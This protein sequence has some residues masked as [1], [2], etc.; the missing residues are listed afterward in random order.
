VKEYLLISEYLNDLTPP[1][2]LPYSYS[3]V[4]LSSILI[5][6]FLSRY[7]WVEFDFCRHLDVRDYID[8]FRGLCGQVTGRQVLSRGATP[9][10]G[11]CRTLCPTDI[12]PCRTATV[13]CLFI[14][15][16]EGRGVILGSNRLGA[17]PRLRPEACLHCQS[18][19]TDS[20]GCRSYH[21]EFERLRFVLVFHSS[22]YFLASW[23]LTTYSRWVNVD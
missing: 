17:S 23:D 6:W 16:F 13:W 21:F 22:L 8:D 3:D 1:R 18:Y 15:R 10:A 7:R 11:L 20:N 4:Y 14:A 2:G 12:G 5:S 19:W 9:A